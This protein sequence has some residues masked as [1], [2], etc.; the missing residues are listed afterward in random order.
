MRCCLNL[1]DDHTDGADGPVERKK[2]TAMRVFDIFT[3]RFLRNE[4]K[5]GKECNASAVTCGIEH[6]ETALPYL[7]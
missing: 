1:D 7:H 2:K 5:T 6:A 3:W 4:K